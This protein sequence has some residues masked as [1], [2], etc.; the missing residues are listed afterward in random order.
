M[1][2]LLGRYLFV[3]F[4]MCCRGAQS[5]YNVVV[6][7]SRKVT[8]PYV[9]REGNVMTKGAGTLVVK[10]NERFPGVGHNAVAS[11]GGKDY[12][13]FHGYDMERNGR[14]ILLSI[15]LN[16]TFCPSELGLIR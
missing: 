15:N 8:G 1:L 11:F 2:K 6:G 16:N 7:R 9:D 5:T 13:F 10:G 3:S 12:L 4:D 14:S